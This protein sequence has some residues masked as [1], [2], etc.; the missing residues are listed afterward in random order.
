MF[1]RFS[2]SV[3]AIGLLSLSACT[4]PYQAQTVGKSGYSQT[5]LAD[6]IFDVWY[7]VAGVHNP[8]RILDYLLLRGAQLCEENGFSHLEHLDPQRSRRMVNAYGAF[9]SAGLSIGGW[10]HTP[11]MGYARVRCVQEPL[12]QGS[13]A[14]EAQYLQ[15]SIQAKYQL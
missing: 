11:P 1:Q 2:A 9:A 15:Q 7:R 12:P 6:D 5:R 4:L 3:L 8:E 10:S 14:L 13:A